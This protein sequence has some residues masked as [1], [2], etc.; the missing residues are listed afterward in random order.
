MQKMESFEIVCTCFS[1]SVSIKSIQTDY[2]NCNEFTIVAIGIEYRFFI[3]YFVRHAAQNNAHNSLMNLSLALDKHEHIICT[4]HES[5][6]ILMK[7]FSKTKPSSC[8][9][10][11]SAI[12]AYDD[13]MKW[14][15]K[16][17]LYSHRAKSLVPTTT[18][19]AANGSNIQNKSEIAMMLIHSA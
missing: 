12:I 7:L 6:P 16:N 2:R 8:Q 14:L 4:A 11:A 18:I 13:N 15:K 3:F 17:S 9:I 10:V 5:L 1:Y 19:I